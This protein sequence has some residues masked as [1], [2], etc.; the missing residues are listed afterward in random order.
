M[1]N[2]NRTR[3]FVADTEEQI[4]TEERALRESESMLSE[5][6]QSLDECRVTMSFLQKMTL[7]ED[8]KT[9]VYE[10]AEKM[11]TFL[12]RDIYF[13]KEDV[14]MRRDRLDTLYHV[15]TTAQSR[16]SGLEVLLY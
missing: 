11:R 4:T 9:S 1:H 12:E 10:H 2:A 14:H 16:V 3:V 13:L 5:L 6:T 15:L 7:Q 8:Q